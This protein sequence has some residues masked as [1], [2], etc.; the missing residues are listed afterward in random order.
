MD[1]FKVLRVSLITWEKVMKKKKELEFSSIDSLILFLLGDR[2]KDIDDYLRMSEREKNLVNIES[3]IEKQVER[4]HKRLGDY[5]KR[6]FEKIFDVEEAVKLS[7]MT[8]LKHL[9]KNGSETESAEKIDVKNSAEYLELKKKY[10]DLLMQDDGEDDRQSIILAEKIR[11]ISL[12]FQP[13]K[14]GFSTVYKAK[15]TQEQYNKFFK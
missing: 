15:L 5:S 11:N 9:N 2:K 13:E 1:K 3:K 4:T 14:G 10:D 12:Y 8:I 7:T 6:Y